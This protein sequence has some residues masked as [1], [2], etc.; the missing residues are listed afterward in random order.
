MP[1]SARKLDTEQEL[2]NDIA[3]FEHDPLGYV[4]YA[5]PWG[6]GELSGHDGPDVWQR[7]LL[8]AVGQGLLSMDQAIQ[9]ARASGH[10]IGKS[11]V[12]AWLILWAMSTKE[13][14]RGV[15]T[16]NTESQLRTKTWPEVAKW[17]RLSINAH[18]FT[19][20]ATA[21]FSKEKT[22]EKTWRIDAVPW[23][24]TNTEAFAGLHNEGKRI[25][26]IFDE[27][28][29]IH[30]LI[31]EVAEGA[32]LDSSTE[33]IWAVFG[34]PTR[35]TGRF[36][37][38]FGKFK[39]R[40]DCKQIDSRNCR[41][42]NKKKIQDWIE[43]Y[44]ED[45][46]FVRVRVKGQFPRASSMQFISSDIVDAALGKVYHQS[47]YQHGP[48]ILGIDVARFGDDQCVIQPRQGLVAFKPKKY[49]GIDNMV[50]AGVVANE[51]REFKP[52][53]VFIDQGAG[54]GVI[55]R[56]RQLGYDII[57]VPFGSSSSSKK[58]V[59][60]RAEMWG[61]MRDWLKQGG[62]L[63][64]DQEIRDDLL[65]PEYGF[66]S[67]DAIQL[68]R[69]E[70]MKKRGLASP[71]CGDALALTFAHPVHVDRFEDRRYENQGSQQAYDPFNHMAGGA[72][73]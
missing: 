53:A 20:T 16:A 22:H 49:R 24:E 52:D 45:S 15:V 59:N 64:D 37:E 35:N 56:L 69:K 51:I 6:S 68:E 31:W 71:D 10:D 46:D 66:T 38:C 7:E 72:H 23:S 61:L 30:N 2:I 28:S 36:R 29:A 32:M 62:A 39:H 1:E 3:G 70:D 26:L 58:Y 27:A 47:E 42:A 43:D 17:H 14:T 33:I 55:D 19:V 60:K 8:E 21:I 50:F 54:T 25:V 48:K 57:E 34:N 41:I 63:P 12:V 40:W 44:G 67:T 13:D 4:M 11:A 18:W 65:G 73:G 9:I 5:F